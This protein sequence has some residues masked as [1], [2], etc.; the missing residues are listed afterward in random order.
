ML[1]FLFDTDIL[2]IFAK[3][4]ALPLLCRLFES[5]RLPITPRV[6]DELLVPLEYGYDF[7]DRIFALAEVVAVE[8]DEIEAYESLRFEGRVSAADAEV[9]AVCQ[10]RGWTYVSMDQ[11]ALRCAEDRRVRTIDLHAIL[12]AMLKGELLDRDELSALIERMEQ[13]DHTTLPYKYSLLEEG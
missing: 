5:E 1:S 10:Q 12:Q 4:R 2:S 3:A 13:E 7:P 11:V 6:F 8:P 9:I